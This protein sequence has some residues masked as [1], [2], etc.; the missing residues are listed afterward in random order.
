MYLRNHGEID[1]GSSYCMFRVSE[2]LSYWES[3]IFLLITKPPSLRPIHSLSQFN[4]QAR[5]RTKVA[6][7]NQ[8]LVLLV[9]CF[10]IRVPTL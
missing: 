8:F 2:G 10:P 9:I 3:T 7:E 5:K 6:R 1:L 4:L